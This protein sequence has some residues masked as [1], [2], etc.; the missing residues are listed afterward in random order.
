MLQEHMF[1]LILNFFWW[2]HHGYFG[3][4]HKLCKQQKTLKILTIL[5]IKAFVSVVSMGK[6][7]GVC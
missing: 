7:Y 2:L 1:R 5:L 4:V 6:V 3:L